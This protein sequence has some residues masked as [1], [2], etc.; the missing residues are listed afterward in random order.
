MERYTPPKNIRLPRK[1]PGIVDMGATSTEKARR[2][3]TALMIGRMFKD[4][5]GSNEMMLET[6]H[7]LEHDNERLL[8][9][10]GNLMNIFHAYVTGNGADPLRWKAIV[11]HLCETLNVPVPEDN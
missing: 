6:I 3:T 2:D 11:D 4:A 1:T 5:T 9:V 8:G 7:H 10:I